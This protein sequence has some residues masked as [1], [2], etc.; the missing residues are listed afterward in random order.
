VDFAGALSDTASLVGVLLTAPPLSSPWTM[1]F[2]WSEF[3]PS[4]SFLTAL[5]AMANQK[6]VCDKQSRTIR[7]S[8]KCKHIRYFYMPIIAHKYEIVKL[9][10]NTVV[11]SDPEKSVFW[12]G[13]TDTAGTSLNLSNSG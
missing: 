5:R 1:G 12:R 6:T 9:E 8:L 2:F 7:L 10:Q 13:E 3:S 4:E 11:L